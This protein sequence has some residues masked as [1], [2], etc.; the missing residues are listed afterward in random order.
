M[1]PVRA[2]RGGRVL[3]GGRDHGHARSTA[4]LAA[5]GVPNRR[6][7]PRRSVSGRGPA[8]APA[9]SSPARAGSRSRSGTWRT[10]APSSRSWW[11]TS[12]SR[13]R[14][15]LTSSP[16]LRGSSAPPT[17]RARP[18][19]GSTWAAENGPMPCHAGK[20][21]LTRRSAG[22]C[23]RRRISSILQCWSI[24]GRSGSAWLLRLAA[25]LALRA[26]GS[27]AGHPE[28][29]SVAEQPRSGLDRRAPGAIPRAVRRAAFG[30][31]R[32]QGAAPGLSPGEA[33]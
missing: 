5:S 30:A 2:S 13:Q 9:R 10:A 17:S 22:L 1:R 23:Q 14:S 28:G 12:T 15:S 27:V 21:D 18:R 24:L 20:T 8:P 16:A 3:L 33:V 31:V 25:V 29:R 32:H 11:R 4:P 19:S 26:E 6:C 7:R